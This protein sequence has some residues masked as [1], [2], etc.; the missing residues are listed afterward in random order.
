M[1][2]CEWY[3]SQALFHCTVSYYYHTAAKYFINIVYGYI[4]KHDGY[5]TAGWN[6]IQIYYIILYISSYN[7]RYLHLWVVK[8][9]Q[10]CNVHARTYIQYVFSWWIFRGEDTILY[11]NIYTYERFINNSKVSEVTERKGSFHFHRVSMH[12]SRF[13]NQDSEQSYFLFNNYFI[14]IT[15]FWNF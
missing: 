13:P 9:W 12:K 6:V 10:V 3:I 15:V 11:I 8:L 4:Y 14:K 1:I 7:F 2:L 5:N